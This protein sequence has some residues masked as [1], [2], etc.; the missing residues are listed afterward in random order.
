MAPKGTRSIERTEE[1]E[2]FMQNLTEF[3]EKRGTYFEAEARIGPKHVSLLALYERVIGEGGYDSVSDTKTR[4]LMWRKFAEE[5]LG[6]SN[7]VAAQA[8]QLKSLYYRNLCA[9]EITEH[10]KEEPPPKE[11]LE[12]VTAKGGNV[13]GRTAE[14][15]EKPLTKEERNL[16]REEESEEPSPVANETPSKE[17]NMEGEPGSAVGGRS[18]RGLRQAPPQRVLFQPDLNTVRAP[19]SSSNAH[20]QSPTP[21]AYMS[22]GINNGSTPMINASANA[23]ATGTL[24]AYEPQQAYPLTLKPVTTPAN[25]PVFYSNERKRKLADVA[26]PLAK[27]YR[28]IMLPGTGF[29]GPNIYIRAQQA[30]QS[31]IESEEAYAL[32]HLVK[33]SHERGEK[34]QFSQFPGLAEALVSYVLRIGRIFWDFDP[35]VSYAYPLPEDDFAT[36]Y[37]DGLYSTTNLL[38]KLSKRMPKFTYGTVMDTTT[39]VELQRITEANLILRN[40]AMFDF[41]ASYL[42]REPLTRDWLTLTLSLPKHSTVTELRVLALEAAEQIVKYMDV[43]E[44]DDLYYSL[45]ALVQDTQD[46]AIAT[47]GFR[48][49]ARISMSLPGPK[50]L[51]RISKEVMQRCA[52]FLMVDD[53]ELRSSVLDFLISFTSFGANVEDLIDQIDIGSL[54]RQLSQLLLFDAKEQRSPTK[55]PKADDDDTTT[56]NDIPPVPRLSRSVVESLTVKLDEPERSSEWLRMCFLPDSRSEMTQISLWQAYQSTFAPFHGSH[57][58]LIAGDFIKNVSS[59]FQGATAQVAGQKYVIRGIRSRKVPVDS[60]L[61]GPRPESRN[62]LSGEKAGAQELLKCSWKA[63]SRVDGPRDPIT[64]LPTSSK[65]EERECGEWSRSGEDIL[66]HIIETHLRIPRKATSPE[67]Y[68]KMEVDGMPNGSTET[69]KGKSFDFSKADSSV[70]RC[71]W[72]GCE[73]TTDSYDVTSDKVPRAVLFARHIS[74]HLPTSLSSGAPGME[75]GNSQQYTEATKQTKPPITG[76]TV[77]YTTMEDEKH[78][79]AGVP[80]GAALVLRNIARGLPPEKPGNDKD[81]GSTGLLRSRVSEVFGEDC[82]QAMT[83]AMVHHKGTMKD[84]VGAVLR[85]IRRSEEGK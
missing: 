1:F 38:D 82:R 4:P 77:M 11:I 16:Q 78:D 73:H 80:L 45:L 20:H 24:A 40:M 43:S 27:K 7:Y 46:R 29:I 2:T 75:T 53:E 12:E 85:Y 41:N 15:F 33:I 19:R 28:H 81:G 22:N 39:H 64:G 74:T 48:T 6:K 34:Y 54:T 17:D 26:T 14:N 71:R 57:P 60:L 70:R 56:P 61:A 32:H 30:L 79:L 63:E 72:S 18:T 37:L 58:H 83:F 42:A 62:G 55:Q 23:A 50:K 52:D 51:E 3:H 31:G 10:W 49:L 67:V 84:Y 69:S 13:R 8:F 66:E 36:D 47:T 35:D 65:V 68:D 21:V 25:N 9:Y 59:T 5:F 44:D 76:E